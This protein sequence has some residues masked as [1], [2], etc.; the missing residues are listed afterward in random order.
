MVWGFEQTQSR[1]LALGAAEHVSLSELTSFRVGGEAALVLR[2]D[3]Y[4]HLK[5]AVSICLDDC[6]PFVLLGRGTNILADD[7]GYDGLVIRFDTPMHPPVYQGTRVIACCGMSLMQLS[8][9]TIARGLMGMERLAGIPGSV[10]GACAMNAGAYGAEIKQILRRIRVLEN[11]ED[12]WIEVTDGDLGYRS[13]AFSFPRRIALEAEFDLQ[14]DDGS[15]VQTMEACMEQRRAKQPLTVPS[16]GS[17]FK[18]PAGY[19]AGALIEQCG[20]KGYAIGDAQV[21]PKHAG[22]IVNNG[23]ATG[24]Q[25]SELIRYVQQTV[26]E[27]AGVHLECEIKRIGG[28]TQECSC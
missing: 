15:A 28:G 27:K 4:E 7:D 6:F 25:I 22:F 17:T 24:K 16:A 2:P 23:H 11:G 26:F 8:R 14:P 18:R 5:Q 19:F 3:S 21:S 9:E 1:L 12:R 10:G 13:S 20:L